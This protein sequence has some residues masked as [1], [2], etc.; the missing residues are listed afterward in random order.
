MRVFSIA[1]ILCLC[2][3]QLVA[4]YSKW[5]IQ[6]TD[7]NNS[8]Y[9]LNDPT[10]YLSQKAIDRRTKQH[11]V[12]DS[13]DL[14]VNPIYIEQVLAK[15]NVT[16]LS[17]AKWLNQILIYCK[18]NN[19]ITA[20]N[21]LPFV[22]KSQAIG[23]FKTTEPIKEKTEDEI[24][25]LD[26]S[27]FTASTMQDTLDY[28]NA[29]NQVHIHNGEFLHNKGYTGDGITIAILDGGFYQYDNLQAFDSARLQNR[30]LGVEDFVDF[31]NSVTEDN[32][33]GMFCLSTI[34]ANVPG[35][36]VGTAPH[37]SFW[38]MRTENV[39]SEYP[40]EEHNWVAAAAFADSAGADIISSSLGYYLFDDP[41]FNHS[42]ADF[43][44][45]S[46]V[47]SKGATMAAQKGMIVTNSAGNEGNNSWKYLIFPADADS[48]CTVGAVDNNGIIASF[49]SY[50]YPGKVKPNIVSV[51][52]GTV[53]WGTNNVPATGSGT[54]F[55]NPNINGLIACLWQAFP[56]DDNMTILNAVY[57]S[58]DKYNN[59]DN[60]Y[61]FGIPNM[62]EAYVILKKKQNIELYGNEWLFASPDPFTSRIDVKVIAQQEGTITL[63]LIDKDGN[64][65][66]SLALN[67]EAQEIYDTSFTGLDNL[68]PG[69][70]NVQY[71]DNENTRTVVL[72]KNGIIMKDWLVVAPVPFNNQL[73]VYL[74]APETGK[75][76]IRLIDVAGRIITS[77]TMN[78]QLNY[79]YTIPF[80][81]IAILPEGVYFVQYIGATK[82][83]VKV[84]K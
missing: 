39:F 4:Q 11:I 32:S 14:P 73:T 20:I 6:F 18:D 80:N 54:S 72:K 29:Y 40:I 59:P 56:A 84:L 68:P 22:K 66:Q 53:I 71:K 5:I 67:A 30:I 36:M 3:T 74:K 57:E 16:Y 17:Q 70:Y 9:S 34:A 27:S 41:T 75:A 42:Y 33:H 81:N 21:Q 61:G 8:P 15:G 55:S 10:A 38:L 62:K 77:T 79:Y 2:S 47:V 65:I 64:T 23:L 50:G 82:K 78:V 1:M 7:K 69:N 12:I 35:K 83:T 45:N 58:A 49:S 25:E 63:S 48:V 26:V 43:Y 19:T 24:K 31:D 60:R 52:S 44:K 13:S 46:T 37:A 76:N 51:G 28:G